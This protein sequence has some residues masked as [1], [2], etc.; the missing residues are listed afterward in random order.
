MTKEFFA[1]LFEKKNGIKLGIG[2][3]AEAFPL[4]KT[5]SISTYHVAGIYGKNKKSNI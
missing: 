1:K 4:V 3:V 5:K 2:R